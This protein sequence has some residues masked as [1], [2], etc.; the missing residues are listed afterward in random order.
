MHTE[1]LKM[2]DSIEKLKPLDIII[3]EGKSEDSDV[4]VDLTD[5][6]NPENESNLTVNVKN[7]LLLFTR[8]SAPITNQ[9]PIVVPTR[10]PS[11]SFLMTYSAGAANHLPKLKMEIDPRL[12]TKLQSSPKPVSRRPSARRSNLPS[13]NKS[14]SSGRSAGPFDCLPILDIAAASVS[15]S[16]SSML[17]P[18]K[19]KKKVRFADKVIIH[20]ISVHKGQTPAPP[21]ETFRL[22]ISL[23]EIWQYLDLDKDKYLNMRE[24]RRFA[25]E[26]W[27]NEDINKM[28]KSYAQHPNKGLSF[29]EWCAV[30]KEE[31]GDIDDLLDDLYDIF[32]E[33]SVTEY[34]EKEDLM[35]RTLSF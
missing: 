28:M 27:E 33:E 29:G 15:M 21:P 32:V 12:V 16:A 26:V 19:P 17:S 9:E 14:P 18:I 25:D 35:E 20:R 22:I 2:N 34:D 1:E 3:C 7:P 13:F 5:N 30:I 23:K 8:H 4:L 31:E 10:K 24:L 11:Q 6:K